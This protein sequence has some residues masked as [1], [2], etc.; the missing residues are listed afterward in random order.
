MPAQSEAPK[1]EDVQVVIDLKKAKRKD[2]K[3]LRRG[4]GPLMEDAA[5]YFEQMKSSGNLNANAVPVFLVVRSKR[6][7]SRGLFL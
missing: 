3:R 6:R 7:K 5:A 2:I 4:E 1:K